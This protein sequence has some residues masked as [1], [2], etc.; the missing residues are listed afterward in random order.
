MSILDN[1]GHLI[2]IFTMSSL[3]IYNK[4]NI[5]L[6]EI[7]DLYKKMITKEDLNKRVLKP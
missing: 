3:D 6:E 4:Y 1:E 5:T 2:D 7:I